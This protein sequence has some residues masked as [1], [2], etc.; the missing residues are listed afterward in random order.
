[1]HSLKQ[2]VDKGI[3]H[4]HSLPIK[5]MKNLLCHYF[6]VKGS[7]KMQTPGAKGSPDSS[8]GGQTHKYIW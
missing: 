6:V 7:A 3:D 5:Q 8:H 4:M 2:D 1:M